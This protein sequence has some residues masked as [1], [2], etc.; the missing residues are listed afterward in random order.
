MIMDFSDILLLIHGHT[1][2]NYYRIQFWAYI[3]ISTT[4]IIQRVYSVAI[5][6]NMFEN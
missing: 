2:R 4:R 5:A 3:D 6:T 1:G